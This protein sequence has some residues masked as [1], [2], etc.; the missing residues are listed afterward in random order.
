MGDDN[1]WIYCI[2]TLVPYVG[3]CVV[4]TLLGEKVA[5]KRGIESSVPKSFCCSVFNGCTCYACTV[6]NESKSYKEN[7]EGVAA[8]KME[9]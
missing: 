7:P 4:L 9:R 6:Y 2:G 3:G 1:G 5:E 8:E